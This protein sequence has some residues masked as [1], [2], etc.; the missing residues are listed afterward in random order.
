MVTLYFI[1]LKYSALC[2]FCSRIC[3]K[4]SFRDVSDQKGN[5]MHCSKEKRKKGKREID[6]I[7]SVAA[8]NRWYC[9][10][11]PTPPCWRV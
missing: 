2:Y 7:N 1:K 6:L 11:A 3:L 5:I 9:N 4:K 8:T 10:R